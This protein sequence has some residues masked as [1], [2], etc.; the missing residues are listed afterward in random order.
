MRLSVRFLD[1]NGD[2]VSTTV[3]EVGGQSE[4]WTGDLGTSVFHHRSETIVVPP[5]ARSFWVV[6]T[7]GGPPAAIGVYAITNLVIKTSRTNEAPRVIARPLEFDSRGAGVPGNAVPFGWIRDG[8]RPSMAQIFEI[9]LPPHTRGF[10]IVDDDVNGHAEWASI[11]QQALP[12]AP[13]DKV[14]LEWD[15]AY[16]FG[17]AAPSEVS[18]L[19]LSAG[20]YRFRINALS[21]MGTPREAEASVAI[22]VPLAFWRQPWFWVAAVAILIA[23]GTAVWRYSL[24]QRMRVEVQRLEQQR[25]V[26]RERLRIAQDIHDDLG[27][28]VTQISLAS[29]MSES[30][31]T[32]SNEARAGFGE[33]SNMAR[34][35]VSAL[36]ETVWSVNPEND[37]IDELANYLCQISNQLCSQSQLRCR[38]EVP[39]KMPSTVLSSQVRHNLILAVKEAVHNVIKHAQASE[40]RVRISLDSSLLKIHIKDDGRGYDPAVVSPGN[41]L[42]NLSNRMESIG[43]N[44]TIS[45]RSDAG[46]EVMLSL[47]LARSG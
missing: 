19:G 42:V 47:P 26:D 16:S 11:K 30:N 24:S 17:L 8:L 28:R 45:G 46:T 3:F 31:P 10:A 40:V 35:L 6:M 33:V 44:F 9:G 37:T 1:G 18:Y 14:V 43:G 41:G 25:A 29:A 32:L 15:E 27:A 2:G 4:G 38:L 39:G 20:Y 21:I 23:I 5:N 36:Y 12:V 22:H 13:G 7:S 34:E